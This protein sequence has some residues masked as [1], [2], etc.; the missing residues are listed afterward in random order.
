M[1]IIIASGYAAALSIEAAGRV[2]NQR[3]ENRGRRPILWQRSSGQRPVC[4]FS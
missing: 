4:L 2:K 3:A 1:S